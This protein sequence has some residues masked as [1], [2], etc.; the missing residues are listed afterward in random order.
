MN[1][2]YHI[3]KFNNCVTQLLK[4]Q[5]KINKEDQDI[6]LLTSLPKSYEIVVT[7]LLVGKIKLI[8]DEVSTALL[9]IENIKQSNSL[10]H[11]PLKWTCQKVL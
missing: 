4:I 5:V 7:K 2:R 9:Q 10:S 8:V 11:T 1:V 6:I 3:N